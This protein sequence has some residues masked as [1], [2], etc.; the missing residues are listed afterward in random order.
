MQLSTY[1]VWAA[2]CFVASWGADELFALD[3]SA[4]HFAAWLALLIAIR[5][6]EVS[7]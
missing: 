7:P 4:S 3:V 2:M 5:G 6:R 1:I